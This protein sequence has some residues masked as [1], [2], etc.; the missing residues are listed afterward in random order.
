MDYAARKT[1]EIYKPMIDAALLRLARVAGADDE[2]VSVT[3]A[4]L[5]VEP[6]TGPW[7]YLT[8]AAIPAIRSSLTTEALQTALGPYS[9]NFSLLKG[10]L[11]DN[12][13]AFD[14]VETQ[15]E[16]EIDYEDPWGSPVVLEYYP[17]ESHECLRQVNY[18][19]G[20]DAD[21]IAL[22][23]RADRTS[24]CHAHME[25]FWILGEDPIDW[26]EKIASAAEEKASA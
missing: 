25:G 16:V 2:A 24:I 7:G 19:G 22:W 1:P 17:E 3:L 26:I 15:D 6:G 13:Q 12:L 5:K 20:S 10:T 18:I 8:Q 21:I 11:A 4:D 23:R 9:W 14:Y